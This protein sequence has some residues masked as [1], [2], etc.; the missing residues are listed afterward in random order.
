MTSSARRPIS[1]PCLPDVDPRRVS[2]HQE[3]VGLFKDDA[4][5][6]LEA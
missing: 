6:G 4:E 5:A 1:F 3:G 2:V